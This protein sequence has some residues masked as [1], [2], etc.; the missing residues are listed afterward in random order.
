MKPV[1]GI[2]AVS[3]PDP[4]NIKTGGEIQLH[5]NYA[6]SIADAGGV[7]VLIPAQAD[8][9][10]ILP[11]LDGIMVP[12]GEDIDASNWGENNHPSVKPVARARFEA[13]KA[14]LNLVEPEMPILGICYGCQLI[15]IT[16]GGSL[17]QHLPEIEGVSEHEG[18]VVQ[19]YGLMKDSQLS[20]F[21]GDDSIRGQSW[22][23]QAIGKVGAGLRVVAH[24]EDNTIEA[25]EACDRPW[26]IGVQWHPERS[27]G[28]AGNKQ[29]FSEFV[30]AAAAYKLKKSAVT[31]G[32]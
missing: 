19:G 7:P 8:P 18:G 23:H 1:I 21:V 25:I 13:E 2:T 15:N 9:A 17:V 29:L 4:S 30:A 22:H 20:S 14:L 12:G 31:S 16:R 3:E 5:W 26:V 6:Q 24:S 11:L 10:E 28:Q 32:K 27:L